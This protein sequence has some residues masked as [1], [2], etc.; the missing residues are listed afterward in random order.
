MKNQTYLS[1]FSLLRG[2][3][4]IHSLIFLLGKTK[5]KNNEFDNK[6][7]DLFRHHYFQRSFFTQIFL[8]LLLC[9]SLVIDFFYTKE[10]F[11]MTTFPFN[12]CL[13][14]L[15]AG[16]AALVAAVFS[17]YPAR[18]FTAYPCVS[19]ESP[20]NLTMR[21]IAANFA[22]ALRRKRRGADPADS[23]FNF[24]F[25][26]SFF[27][28]RFLL[29]F[30]LISLIFLA[31]RGTFLQNIF[32]LL[33]G[34]IITSFS[35]S[36]SSSFV[37]YLGAAA[38]FLV[39]AHV[40]ERLCVPWLDG[41]A[42]PGAGR[43]TAHGLRLDGSGAALRL[44]GELYP[45]S[46]FVIFSL[47]V[48]LCGGAA[49]VYV[50]VKNNDM[51]RS[52]WSL[53]A[54]KM[55]FT[56]DIQ[57]LLHRMMPQHWLSDW[58]SAIEAPGALESTLLSS[59]EDSLSRD[60][61]SKR[62]SL[63]Y[64]DESVEGPPRDA[65]PFN[66]RVGTAVTKSEL[67]VEF[68]AV[69]FI[70]LHIPKS[71][72]IYKF[73]QMWIAALDYL[74]STLGIHKLKS[75]GMNYIAF[76]FLSRKSKNEL[77]KKYHT[78]LEA[79][80]HYGNV[81]KWISDLHKRD[82]ENKLTDA[83]KELQ[84]GLTRIAFFSLVSIRLLSY[85]QEIIKI[86][87]AYLSKL[88]C[89]AHVGEVYGGVIGS[90]KL[91]YDVFGTTINAT[92]RLTTS[93]DMNTF[94]TSLHFWLLVKR[95]IEP[96]V[97]ANLLGPKDY[98]GLK[99]KLYTVEIIPKSLPPPFLNVLVNPYN[100]AAHSYSDDSFSLSKKDF[101]SLPPE[102]DDTCS[103]PD[104]SRP[105]PTSNSEYSSADDRRLNSIHHIDDH[106]ISTLLW[107]CLVYENSKI[108]SYIEKMIRLVTTL[109]QSQN[110]LK[111]SI[112]LSFFYGMQC[113]TDVM[114]YIELENALR[115]NDPN[116]EQFETLLEA[117]ESAQKLPCEKKSDILKSRKSCLEFSASVLAGS[118]TS[119]NTYDDYSLHINPST[120]HMGL[121]IQYAQPKLSRSVSLRV[122]L[123]HLSSTRSFTEPSFQEKTSPSI[124]VAD[125]RRLLP[126]IT[127]EGTIGSQMHTITMSSETPN[128]N[129]NSTSLS[130]HNT[131]GF[132]FSNYN[133]Y[134]ADSYSSYSS[135]TGVRPIEE[136]AS[137][138]SA[139]AA[140]RRLS[141]STPPIRSF[142]SES[143]GLHVPPRICPLIESSSYSS[144][145]DLSRPLQTQASLEAP[146]KRPDLHIL[147]DETTSATG[148]PR[149]ATRL[150]KYNPSPSSEKT[151]TNSSTVSQTH[152]SEG[153]HT[154]KVLRKEHKPHKLRTEGVPALAAP[155]DEAR[156]PS[157]LSKDEDSAK[158]PKKDIFL[159]ISQ[160]LKFFNWRY[161]PKQALMDDT[162]F[163]FDLFESLENK[164]L[165]TLLHFVFIWGLSL[166]PTL[167][168]LCAGA[169]LPARSVAFLAASLLTS[170]VDLCLNVKMRK[171]FAEIMNFHY[172]IES[173]GARKEPKALEKSVLL[174]EIFLP[175]LRGLWLVCLILH[176]ENIVLHE[177]NTKSF[178]SSYIFG[179]ADAE[180]VLHFYFQLIII[181]C[182]YVFS[183]YVL[184]PKIC[185][186]PTCCLLTA[187][188][189]VL[190]HF[191][192]VISFSFVLRFLIT[193][194]IILL[195]GK[196]IINTT[197]HVLVLHSFINNT[198][199]LILQLMPKNLFGNIFLVYFKTLLYIFGYDTK[200]SSALDNLMP[201][202]HPLRGD[203]A[204]RPEEAPRTPRSRATS[205]E[206]ACLMSDAPPTP[207]STERTC[208]NSDE[209][210]GFSDTEESRPGSA[211]AAADPPYQSTSKK[212]FVQKFDISSMQEA[213]DF[214]QTFTTGATAKS[215]LKDSSRSNSSEELRE[216]LLSLRHLHNSSAPRV[217]RS[218]VELQIKSS[219]H[220]GHPGASASTISLTCALNNSVKVFASPSKS[221][222]ISKKN[223]SIFLCKRGI[224][225]D[226]SPH[227]MS[228]PTY[229]VEG[230]MSFSREPRAGVSP[231]S[232][233]RRLDGAP[234]HRSNP[235]ADVS[236]S[237]SHKIVSH[238]D[239]YDF[240]RRSQVLKLSAFQ[241]NNCS[242]VASLTY[243]A[244]DASP[245]SA[246]AG[247]RKSKT[248]SSAQRFPT[249]D[250]HRT[251]PFMQ[252]SSP[253]VQSIVLNQPSPPFL[254]DKRLELPALYLT[255]IPFDY[256][257]L[258]LFSCYNFEET[259]SV[260]RS[261]LV[262]F[263]SFCSKSDPKTI[264]HM[265]CT[266]FKLYDAAAKRCGVEKIRTIGDAFEGVSGLTMPRKNPVLETIRLAFE[267][268]RCTEEVSKTC[269]STLKVRV[270][271]A[272]GKV[273]GAVV[274]INRPRFDIFGETVKRA[275]HLESIAPV[276]QVAVDVK[277]A[278]LLLGLP[279]YQLHVP[280]VYREQP[281]G[282]EA[283]PV[284]HEQAQCQN[285]LIHKMLLDKKFANAHFFVSQTPCV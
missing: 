190:H 147:I 130:P 162:I 56:I 223:G 31:L 206:S 182:F 194:S 257:S 90:D 93:A 60:G 49:L 131:L 17:L 97:N 212:V 175:L 240:S 76:F 140:Q 113:S 129:F 181:I 1:F 201:F 205:T 260:L 84:H 211:L 243:D 9:C 187:I 96:F 248:V 112:S 137:T 237:K 37:A 219:P 185:F 153:L 72:N 236:F 12:A 35:F 164:F 68:G 252:K 228:S 120:P 188:L 19:L 283:L 232:S 277:S 155:P 6:I 23:S 239:S 174:W 157:H 40:R 14:A 46:Q 178:Y 118:N 197:M 149:D 234:G 115:V 34:L 92:A 208:P 78:R 85:I 91:M 73:I 158:K 246:G 8:I 263:T 163:L 159:I 244:S 119:S 52:M 233:P 55:I 5:H 36:F 186:F 142:T 220:F 89:G 167:F 121:F 207:R 75:C 57:S 105:A 261:D 67:F 173:G 200:E 94:C 170:A 103:S 215:A 145:S 29:F 227:T 222:S 168:L 195:N 238:K 258:C 189:V 53:S 7:N 183:S 25:F 196:L 270:G 79:R 26:S 108:P 80:T 114:E 225:Q 58:V 231:L 204:P 101:A 284:L 141:A 169:A 264:I 48:T 123:S 193:S 54:M 281:A 109:F 16:L 136:T 3:R 256:I 95:F 210:L 259:V 18:R 275:E 99:N 134:S 117:T 27:F 128:E 279:Q 51:F 107:P 88:H 111:K 221:N 125:G 172:N 62:K 81:E 132:S 250:E 156:G 251:S 242:Q 276:E 179:L 148:P 66:P 83:E 11:Q 143:E 209:H 59:V 265:L 176:F 22:G 39:A 202:S 2:N 165:E 100:S 268:I 160:L 33:F 245:L 273:L 42:L 146:P 104:A 235:A 126:S 144:A 41:Y 65:A 267:L 262:G 133:S 154:V 44:F 152:F 217:S 229:H 180:N 21:N 124:P 272:T 61:S 102:G 278:R 10:N 86:P 166:A 43:L 69:T 50:G 87:N 116:E 161:L 45:S 214:S 199:D 216:G 285:D 269:S 71:E 282:A 32:T 4:S 47:A 106:I 150:K 138:R 191:T 38:A 280:T 241:V 63:T 254:T 13:A 110:I 249:I 122:G 28:S 127:E 74:A 213:S 253:D 82:M 30:L 192:R 226:T 271:I 247:P 139:T 24:L 224:S 274:G 171:M 266:L 135:S 98:K 77:L 218:V 184:T 64:S 198:C 20:N 15:V 70:N 177:S 255:G 230:M 203:T 151:I